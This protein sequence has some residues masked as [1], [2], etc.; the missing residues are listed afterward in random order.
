VRGDGRPEP[1]DRQPAT[2]AG[3]EA[4]ARG[5]PRGGNRETQEAGGA[6]AR[7]ATLPREVEEVLGKPIEALS[8]ARLGSG[9]RLPGCGLHPHLEVVLDLRLR[10][11]GAQRHPRAAAELIGDHVGGWKATDPALVVLD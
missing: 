2:R 11:G 4:P 5:R 9:D 7:L 3:A 10:A 6:L 1:R 8:A